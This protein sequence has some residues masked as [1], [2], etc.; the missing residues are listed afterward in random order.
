MKTISI[1]VPVHNLHEYIPITLEN[2]TA[3]QFTSHDSEQWELIVVDDGSTDDSHLLVEPFLERYPQSVKLLRTSNRGVS[4]ARNTA[5][6]I[7]GGRYIFFADGD[8][9]VKRH[10][11]PE[12]IAV[13]GKYD[14]DVLH[15]GYST[16]DAAEYKALAPDIPVGKA[17]A[18]TA[19]EITAEEFLDNT[20]GMAGPPIHWNIWQNLFSR[21]F[22]VENRCRF[23]EGLPLGEDAVFM[24]N[25]MLLSPKVV[26]TAEQFYIYHERPGS[27]I[28]NTCATHIGRM[29]QG[30]LA[31]LEHLYKIHDTLINRG[32]GPAAVNGVSLEIRNVFYRALADKLLCGATLKEITADIAHYKSRGGEVRPGRPRFNHCPN[33]RRSFVTELRRWL[34]AYPIGTYMK[35]S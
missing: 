35:L 7:A 32:Y 16:V 8:D 12:L 29:T 6:D 21:K 1:I 33:M 26:C 20:N 25:V 17:C 22:L 28:H 24:W 27:A 14:C 10:A 4:A 5:L 13:A 19:H 9:L 2:L 23:I 18:N 3:Q 34:T 30:R 15:F 11:L 31:Y